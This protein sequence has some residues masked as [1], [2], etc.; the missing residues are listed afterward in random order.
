M[1]SLIQQRMAIDRQRT[2]ARIYIVLGAFF[3]LAGPVQLIVSKTSSPSGWFT[4]AI[5]AMWL[6]LGL[7]QRGKSNKSRQEFEAE[8][9]EHA[10]QQ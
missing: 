7:V 9:G 4:L 8:H 3:F 6:I 1:A 10:G 2:F 5:G